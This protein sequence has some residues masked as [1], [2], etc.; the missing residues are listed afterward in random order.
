MR[1]TGG[2]QLSTNYPGLGVFL[3][4]RRRRPR[5]NDKCRWEKNSRRL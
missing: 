3:P 5:W 2:R 1:I 4:L